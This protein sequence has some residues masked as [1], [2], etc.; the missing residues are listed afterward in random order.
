MEKIS[1]SIFPNIYKID[2]DGNYQINIPEI[3]FSFSSDQLFEITENVVANRLVGSS[4]T[5]YYSCKKIWQKI[6]S[7]K[8]KLKK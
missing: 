7:R 1:K 2:K 5:A 8:L 3:F 6:F 4:E